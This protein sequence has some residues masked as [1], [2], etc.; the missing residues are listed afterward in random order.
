R[1]IAQRLK[2]FLGDRLFIE[3]QGHNPPEMNEA[4]LKIA[5]QEQIKPVITSDCHYAK[6]EDIWIEDAMLILSTNPDLQKGFDF[7]RSQKMDFLER[8]NYLYPGRRMSFQDIEVFLKS[9][10]EHHNALKHQ[11]IDR[12][13]VISNTKLVAD[14]IGE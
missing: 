14:S 13:D 5:D 3:V 11:G 9:A 8:Y 12:T 2:S 4:L 1:T 10:E 6:Q 7:T